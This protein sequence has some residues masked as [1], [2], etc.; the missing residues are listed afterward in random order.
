M[1]PSGRLFTS[2]RKGGWKPRNVLSLIFS[3]IFATPV[4]QVITCCV[5]TIFT[6]TCDHDHSK[7]IQILNTKC[8][9][10]RFF[11]QSC[12]EPSNVKQRW[13]VMYTILRVDMSVTA[14]Q[15]SHIHQIV[16]IPYFYSH[17]QSCQKTNLT[18]H[19]NILTGERQFDELSFRGPSL[20][21][22]N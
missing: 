21:N 13:I 9:N 22:E 20:L 5:S 8:A 16:E 19:H 6:Y 11:A 18:S 3:A 7:N 1:W 17:F 14:L 15:T 10:V 4:S 12:Y 2:N